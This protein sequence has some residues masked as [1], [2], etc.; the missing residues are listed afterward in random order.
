MEVKQEGINNAWQYVYQ[1]EPEPYYWNTITNETTF[2]INENLEI[3]RDQDMK[4]TLKNREKILAYQH[5]KVNTALPKKLRRRLRA[6]WS[7]F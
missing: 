4:F 7:F 2:D 1:N 5:I 3:S 6:D